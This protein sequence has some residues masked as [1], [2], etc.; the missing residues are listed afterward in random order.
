MP[1]VTSQI[2]EMADDQPVDAANQWS[3]TA[4]PETKC[5]L[6]GGKM[7]IAGEEHHLMSALDQPNW[8]YVIFSCYYCITIL[9]ID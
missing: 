8:Q 9:L 7:E 1:I 6:N 2:A 4:P 5:A 3:A